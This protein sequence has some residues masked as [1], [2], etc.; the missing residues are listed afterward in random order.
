MGAFSTE[1]PAAQRSGNG[2]FSPVAG[3]RLGIGRPGSP[4]VEVTE[5]GLTFVARGYRPSPPMSICNGSPGATGGVCAPVFGTAS[6]GLRGEL[7][8]TEGDDGSAGFAGL[9]SG[10]GGCCVPR[11]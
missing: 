7:P 5:L 11:F 6:P 1:I 4:V 8:V 2:N 10:V 3:I 9:G